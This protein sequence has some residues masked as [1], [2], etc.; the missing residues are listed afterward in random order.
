M[1]TYKWQDNFA[2]GKYIREYDGYSPHYLGIFYGDGLKLGGEDQFMHCAD[3]FS[4]I[5]DVEWWDKDELDALTDDQQVLLYNIL[6]RNKKIDDY[7]KENFSLLRNC[8]NGVENYKIH[9]LPN[10][11]KIFVI[12]LIERLN[13]SNNLISYCYENDIK[14]LNFNIDNPFGEDL[15]RYIDANF[16]NGLR[17]NSISTPK[18]C[19]ESD[20]DYY[21]NLITDIEG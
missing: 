5:G 16:R 18:L 21:S 7:I 2:S 3:Y 1:N 12:Y 11:Y 15:S 14:E 6:V 4:G 17:K 13:G 20:Y 19:E 9:R 8:F 10:K